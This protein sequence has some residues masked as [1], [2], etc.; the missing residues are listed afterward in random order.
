MSIVSASSSSTASDWWM[1]NKEGEEDEECRSDWLFN[2]CFMAESQMLLIVLVVDIVVGPVVVV[3]VAVVVIV[4]DVAF[5]ARLIAGTF[6]GRL[7]S[8]EEDRTTDD[9]GPA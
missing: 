3:I 1:S 7:E 6:N 2:R 9:E 4:G 8:K 5:S